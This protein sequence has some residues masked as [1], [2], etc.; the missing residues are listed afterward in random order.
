[1]NW[2][3]CRLK[4]GW[5]HCGLSDFVFRTVFS[6]LL[7]IIALFFFHTDV[8]SRAH[9]G[10]V[11]NLD[12]SSLSNYC[13]KSCRQRPICDQLLRVCV[14]E[15]DRVCVFVVSCGGSQQRYCFPFSGNVGPLKHS[16]RVLACS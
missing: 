13:T 16:L 5:T 12:Q 6:T 7:R 3:Y 9:S 2:T 4:V 15:R 1:M 11:V 10:F 14:S 8:S